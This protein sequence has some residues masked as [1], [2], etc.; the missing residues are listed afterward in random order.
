[1][2]W[3]LLAF[4]IGRPPYL[5]NYCGVCRGLDSASIFMCVFDGACDCGQGVVYI[6]V[7]DDYEA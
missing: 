4:D 6:K 7:R 5:E 2:D 1:M 3:T